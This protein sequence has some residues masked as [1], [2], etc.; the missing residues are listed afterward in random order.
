MKCKIRFGKFKCAGKK[1]YPFPH[2]TA[3]WKSTEYKDKIQPPIQQPLK[4][5]ITKVEN[6]ETKKPHANKNT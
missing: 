6:T 3:E 5:Q 4:P 2:I 1:K